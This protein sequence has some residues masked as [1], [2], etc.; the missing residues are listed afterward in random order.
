MITTTSS[1]VEILGNIIEGMVYALSSVKGIMPSL[2]SIYLITDEQEGNT[3]LGEV[4]KNKILVVLWTPVV[5]GDHSNISR[6]AG[7]ILS[8]ISQE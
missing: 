1:F 3:S 2:T 4:C 6:W 7:A 8:S 5:E